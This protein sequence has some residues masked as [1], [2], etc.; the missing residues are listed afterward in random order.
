[1]EKSID[2]FEQTSGRNMDVKDCHWG[3][4]EVKSTVEKAYIVFRI[5]KLS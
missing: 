2:Y 5:P 3:L 1:M 4:K